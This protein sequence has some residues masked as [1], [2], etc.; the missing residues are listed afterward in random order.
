VACVLGVGHVFG[1]VDQ[2][3]VQAVLTFADDDRF[4]GQ[5]DRWVGGVAQVRHEDTL[6]NGCALGRLHVLHI[7]NFFGESFVE[8]SRLDFEG[9]LRTFEAVFEV[10]ERG[11]GAGRDVEAVHHG[12]EPGGDDKDRERA[13]ESPDSHAA[14]AHGGDFAVGGEAAEADQDSQKHAHGQR[15]GERERHGEE[16]N[17]GDAGQGSAG[18]DNQFED[19]SQVAGEQ[20]KGK[21]RHADERE[22]RHFA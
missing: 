4:L 22:R 7:E 8:N 1:A 12:H 11:L 5:G 3:Q 20:D 14:G 10:A 21:D 15:V 2:V 13:Q 18:T 9:D 17:L 16:E 6:P 19:A